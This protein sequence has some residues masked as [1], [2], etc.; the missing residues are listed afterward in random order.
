MNSSVKQEVTAAIVNYGNPIDTA[1]L[2]RKIKS[3]VKEVI[4]V[5]NSNDIDGTSAEFKEVSVIS[6]PHNIG[7]GAAINLAAKQTST[8]WLLILNP[9]VR[10]QK[11]CLDS[12][13]EAS[14]QLS[15]P[16]CGP[17]FYWDDDCTLQLPPALGHPLWL[18]SD[19]HIPNNLSENPDLGN[20]AITRH[21]RFW[22][23]TAPFNE[24]VLSGACMLLDNHWFEEN[25]M[26]IFDE[27]FF[28]YYEDTD[29]CARLMSKGV[30]PICVADASA[31]HYWD[32]SAEPPESKSALMAVSEKIFLQ[33][34][35]PNG[36]P[37]LPQSTKETA[38]TDLGR[39]D[40]PLA[41]ILPAKSC[42]LDIGV[43]EDFIVFARSNLEQPSF[44]FSLPMWR[45]LRGSRYYLRALDENGQS[46]QFWQFEKQ[47]IGVPF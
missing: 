7:F 47:S 3:Q 32:Q 33:K 2:L 25:K 21:V 36:A 18:L 27:D 45:R 41:L 28:L 19:S 6:L 10:L 37:P 31:V 12:L 23:E 40:S 14:K 8:R 44:T 11:N 22:N 39:L 30:M 34:Y 9:D 4:V 29:L 13:L 5:D 20:L 17:R 35:Y 42:Q 26:P 24:P 43:Q 16:L 15:A 38:F 1:D 46:L